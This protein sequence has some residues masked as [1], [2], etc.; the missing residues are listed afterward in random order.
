MKSPQTDGPKELWFVTPVWG[1]DYWSLFTRYC[2]ASLFTPGNLGALGGHTVRYIIF[3]KPEEIEIQRNDPPIRE[4]S[5]QADVRFVAIGP[6]VFKN[7][8]NNNYRIMTL[9]HQRAL[10]LGNQSDAGFVFMMPDTLTAEGSLKRVAELAAGGG[11]AI[12]ITALR[13]RMKEVKQG[14]ERWRQSDRLGSLILPPRP[15]VGLAIRNLHPIAQGHYQDG[16]GNRKLGHHYWPL[17]DQ[18]VL[19]R[20]FHPLPFF[21]WPEVKDDRVH[22]TI[23]HDLVRRCVPNYEDVR[24]IKDSDEIFS[25]ELVPEDYQVETIPAVPNS[26]EMVAEWALKWTNAYHRK[27]VRERIVL[28]A[29][30]AEVPEE[31]KAESDRVIDRYISKIE[32][33]RGVLVTEYV[34]AE[35]GYL[36]DDLIW[37]VQ[38]LQKNGDLGR[39]WSLV[40]EFRAVNAELKDVESI[41]HWLKKMNM[42]SECAS[43]A[44]QVFAF[45]EGVQILSRDVKTL[46]ALQNLFGSNGRRA[47][48]VSQHFKMKMI[49]GANLAFLAPYHPDWFPPAEALILE[50]RDPM[51][52][53]DTAVRH[54]YL[55]HL[56]LDWGRGDQA[57]R[58]WQ[59]VM[60]NGEVSRFLDAPGPGTAKLSTLIALSLSQKMAYWRQDES[61]AELWRRFSLEE[62]R[63]YFR[64]TC[65]TPPFYMFCGRMARQAAC[66]PDGLPAARELFRGSLRLLRNVSGLRNPLYQTLGAQFLTWWAMAEAEAG[67][68]EDA[69]E[70]MV[71]VMALM[72]DI[73]RD[74]L[75]GSM[76]RL[77]DGQAVGGWFAGAWED[78]RTV[79]WRREFNPEACRSFLKRFTFNYC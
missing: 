48:S 27:F 25:C 72:E 61:W 39:A 64:N 6:D 50:A 38:V 66:R 65:E 45:E 37:Q 21:L 46:S 4:L 30:G 15:L 11:R 70:M 42:L 78:L 3:T 53:D 60:E 76:L 67:A 1:S 16:E 7:Y 58:E 9:C 17:G 28:H 34:Q 47:V 79:N 24:V 10:T 54:Q 5:R 77:E 13:T 26:D 59:A 32:T 33:F 14:V 36:R 51:H 56:Y 73:G 52:L 35:L 20:C 22:T 19:I 62:L 31:T 12:M 29:G 23:E 43:V 69:G 41:E 63:S 71:R 68:R 44:S 49:L 57:R 8:P 55:L 75:L 2:L 74:E 18:G 40:K